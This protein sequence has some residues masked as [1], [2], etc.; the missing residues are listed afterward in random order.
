MTIEEFCE[1]FIEKN[2]QCVKNIYF[3]GEDDTSISNSI[4]NKLKVIRENDTTDETPK[5][6]FLNDIRRHDNKYYNFDDN[7]S[8]EVVNN[9]SNR[10]FKKIATY[11]IINKNSAIIY[12]HFD[13]EIG[14]NLRQYFY[15]LYK[16]DNYELIPYNNN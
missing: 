4:N 10:H 7:I 6:T 13:S 9:D 3:F 16:N 14:S 5:I 12:L 1:K 15:V 2:K 11:E 8:W